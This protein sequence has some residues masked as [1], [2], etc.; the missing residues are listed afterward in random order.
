M[1][2]KSRPTLTITSIYKQR[3]YLKGAIIFTASDI[4]NLARQLQGVEQ[5]PSILEET[6][7]IFLRK[8]TSVILNVSLIPDETER[9]RDLAIEVGANLHQEPHL[10]L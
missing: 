7:E 10:A 5:L 9:W 6:A 8:G 4:W 2:I 1:E 3:R